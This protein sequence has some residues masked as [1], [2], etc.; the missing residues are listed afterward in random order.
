MRLKIRNDNMKKIIYDFGANN[1]DNIPYYLLKADIVVAVEANPVLCEKIEHRFKEEIRAGILIVKNF[2]LHIGESTPQTP[3]YVHKK[4]YVLSQYPIPKNIEEFEKIYLPAKNVIE[5]IREIGVPY[6]IK[7]DLEHYDHMILRELFNNNI[8]PDYISSESHSVEIFSILVSLGKY[9]AFKLVDGESINVE[10]SDCSIKTNNGAINYSFPFHSA[11]PFGNEVKGPWMKPDNFF[12]VLALEGLGWKDIHASK[13]DIADREHGTKNKISFVTV[14]KG[15]LSH[16]KETLPRLIQEFPNE[17]IFVDYSCPE[18]SGDYVIK[19]FPSVKVL[20]I[21]DDEFFCLPRARNL[22]AAQ[23]SSDYIC[24]I[25][26]DI[27]VQPG[28]VNWASKNVN[29][30]SFYRHEKQVDGERDKETWGTFIVSRDNFNKIGGYDE[31]IRGW[32]GEDDDIYMRLKLAEVHEFAFPHNLVC[33]IKHDDSLRT[34]FHTVKSKDLQ[35]LQNTV[36][37]NLKILMLQASN[38][39]YAPITKDLDYKS[40]LALQDLINSKIKINEINQNLLFGVFEV[41]FSVPRIGTI[42]SVETEIT[43]KFQPKK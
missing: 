13:I 18:N 8:F 20:K 41:K 31:A 3:F 16:I 37:L 36:Y 27:N 1:G 43:I 38:S 29:L 35:G 42:S 7:I 30:N 21:T 12:K 39:I 34:T 24:F 15:R 33:A 26:A 6:Y 17:I 32:G 28:F 4:N 10:Y 2:V 23:A 9:E 40:R 19:N 22:G 5:L 25:D 11:G 14:C